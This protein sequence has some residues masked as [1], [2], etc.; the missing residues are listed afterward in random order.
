[1]QVEFRKIEGYDNY[2]VSNTGLVRNDSTD[3]TLS[4][5]ITN[6]YHRVF[7]FLNNKGKRFSVHRLVAEAFIPNLDNKSCVDH[8]DNNKLNNH[9]DN[10]RWCTLQENNRNR[11]ICGKNTNGIKGVTWNKTNNKWRAQINI[12]NRHI[13]IDYFNTL[14]EAAEARSR[15]AAENFGDFINNCEK[16]PINNIN[17]IENAVI[18]N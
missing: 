16:A 15:V 12:N 10:L 13:H 3:K 6:G 11:S 5:D 2:S 7:L 14:E 4:P 1:M 8:I 18:N 9:V 17:I